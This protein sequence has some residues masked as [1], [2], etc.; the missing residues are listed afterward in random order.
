MTERKKP[1]EPEYMAHLIHLCDLVFSYC[2]P[3]FHAD[4]HLNLLIL[5][6]LLPLFMLLLNRAYGKHE[7][8]KVVYCTCALRVITVRVAQLA[9]VS[10]MYEVGRGFDPCPDH[11][12]K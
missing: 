2:K 6:R 3:C 8:G 9:K 12:L 11:Y 5:N 7:N 1:T 4:Q 10:D